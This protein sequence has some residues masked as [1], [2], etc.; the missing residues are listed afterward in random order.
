MVC[1]RVGEDGED[2]EER[3]VAIE[4]WESGCGVGK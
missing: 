3:W 4:E 1:G 2:G